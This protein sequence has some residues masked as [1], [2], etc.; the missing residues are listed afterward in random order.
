MCMFVC[1]CT[2][3]RFRL[4]RLQAAFL[5]NNNLSQIEIVRWNKFFVAANMSLAWNLQQTILC[6]CERRAVSS[7]Q[8][9]RLRTRQV[10]VCT[11]ACTRTYVSMYA[12]VLS[13]FSWKS[14]V[15]SYVNSGGGVV[16]MYICIY[17][18]YILY[19]HIFGSCYKYCPVNGKTNAV[20]W[21]AYNCMRKNL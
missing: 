11:S 3:A 9:T 15:L 14:H 6:F 17:Y 4:R 8:R 16:F 13:C 20:G 18:I 7:E 19:V 1:I 5:F 21:R 10:S 2:C 12:L